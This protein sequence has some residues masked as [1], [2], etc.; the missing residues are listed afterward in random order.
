MKLFFKFFIFLSFFILNNFYSLH[1]KEY[2]AT[3]LIE[4]KTVNI[5]KLL[6]NIN[7][8]KNNYKMSLILEDKG[9][10][11][12]IYKFNG[13]YEV[14]GLIINNSLKPLEYQQ[15][16][17]TKKKERKVKITFKNGSLNE[18]LLFPEEKELPRIQ[19]IGLQNFLDPLSSF[20]NLLIGENNSKTIDG[21]RAYILV[22]DKNSKKGKVNV[23]KILI[24]NY[25]N[26][27]TDHKKKDLE[28]IEIVQQLNE[29]VEILPIIINIK[30]K[31][32]LFKLRKI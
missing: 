29:T 12:S 2:R 31:D 30:F 13:K 19:Y 10:F 24:K 32:I 23:R 11:S 6:W 27:W 26:I 1:A 4:V 9:F 17:I 20:L 16:W 5:G 25:K 18:L 15:V 8:S 28:Y 21:R 14:S 3:Y 7:I 22:V